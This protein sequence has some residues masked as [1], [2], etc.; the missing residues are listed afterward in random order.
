MNTYSYVSNS[1]LRKTDFYGLVEWDGLGDISYCTYY[2][3]MAEKNPNCKYYKK[4]ADICRGGSTQVN[5]LTE[6]GILFGD[7]DDDKKESDIFNSIRKKLIFYDRQAQ[8]IGRTDENGCTCGDTIDFYH[9]Q[10]FEESGLSPFFYGGSYWP[11]N[12][13]MWPW[14]EYDG[15]HG[16]PIPYDPRG[17]DP[18]DDYFNK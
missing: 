7:F 12:R 2:D 6:L 9:L 13:G 1:P 5:R 11:Q 15:G 4:A 16:N 17:E 8:Q 10:A 18:A 3:R 14:S